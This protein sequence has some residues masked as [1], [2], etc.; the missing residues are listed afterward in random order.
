MEST[1]AY[2][3]H[4]VEIEVVNPCY[5]GSKDPQGQV[6][7]VLCVDQVLLESDFLKQDNVEKEYEVIRHRLDVHIRNH[8]GVHMKVWG[9]A[10]GVRVHR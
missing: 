4:G 9:V 1:V 8:E 2:L 7:V 3:G 10:K 5:S 6:K